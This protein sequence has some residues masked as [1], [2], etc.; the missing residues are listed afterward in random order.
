MKLKNFKSYSEYYSKDPNNFEKKIALASSGS[1]HPLFE[2]FST[3]DDA[4]T[5]TKSVPVIIWG[6]FRFSSMNENFCSVVYNQGNIPSKKEI[7][8]VFKEEDF[9]PKVVKDR[10]L[11]KKMSF[12]I[13]GVFGEEEE[14]FKTYGQFKKSERF[15]DHFK[16]K[17]VPT[18]KFEVLAVD[19]KPVHAHKKI[20]NNSFDIDL[21]RW[22]HLGEAESICKKIHSKY[23]P[24]FYV[25]SL[26]EANGQLYLDSITR[27]ID[28]T[29]VQS[30]R[31]YEAAYRKYYETD[32][33]YWFRKK[34]F[35]DHVKPYYIKKYYDS[36]LI[37]P[38]GTIDY[39]KYLN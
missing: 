24:D 3:F 15:F 2:N 39:E 36:L 21:T 23:S 8:A 4:I 17:L 5:A 6:N 33:P 16:E 20:I 26:L 30:V 7:S 14:D 32:L 22:K 28:L 31:L 11:I 13:T 29:P 9:V 1:Q 12:P 19:G 18:S 25:V 38:T 34:V 10:S 35:E 27:N 37:K